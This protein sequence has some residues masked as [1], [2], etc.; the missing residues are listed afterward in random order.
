L[1]DVLTI[2]GED[3]DFGPMPG[4]ASLPAKAIG[5]DWFA[6]PGRGSALC[7]LLC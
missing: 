1:R 5:S 6:G 7:L 2:H 3:F 4:G